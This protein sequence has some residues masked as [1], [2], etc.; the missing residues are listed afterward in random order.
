M[1]KKISDII[2]SPS[3]S[4][5]LFSA[6][7][8][9]VLWSYGHNR[10]S[11]DPTGNSKPIVI[12][13]S[14][15]TVTTSA[16]KIVSATSVTTSGTVSTTKVTSTSTVSTTVTSYRTTAAASLSTTV[17]EEISA[18]PEIE[19]TDTMSDTESP[20]SEFY[21][22]RLVIAGDSIA[23]GFSLYGYIPSEHSIATESVGIWNYDSFTFNV[24]FGDMGLLDAV[25]YLQPQLLYISMGM[26]DMPM[27]SPDWFAN[28][29]CSLIMQIL[30]KSPNTVVVAAGVT[31]VTDTVT[32]TTNEN[33]RNY[34]S[35]L[36]G[37]IEGL[38]S[39]QVYYF[40]AYPVL[41]YDPYSSLRS[42]CS[43]GDGIHIA[44]QCY[45]NILSNLYKKLDDDNVKEQ[46]L[47]YGQ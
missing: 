10:N 33:I 6:A 11:G 14:V 25:A 13:A 38:G 7:M 43:A 19:N 41:A 2:K 16:E 9:A 17:T 47:S 42:E 4:L 8:I 12:K 36:E 39:P 44:S 35:A 23:S 1:K 15:D 24:G 18:E 46:I 30:E 29:Y 34:N 37:M 20:N 28:E 32:Y 3:F 31:P 45:Y 40:D 27:N 26:N 5:L 22:E 21:H